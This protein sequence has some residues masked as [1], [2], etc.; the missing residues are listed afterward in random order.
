MEQILKYVEE[1]LIPKVE[2]PEFKAGD[3]VTVH[4]KIIEGEKVRIQQ[5]K[6]IVI[7][8][9][10]GPKNAK[11]TFTVRKISSGIG[12]ERVFPVSSPNIE[13]IEVNRYGKVRRARLFYLR[14]AQG[15][16]ARI[17]ERRVLTGADAKGKND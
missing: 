7:Q 1:Q 9:K 16:R 17:K 10:G 4:Y 8:I 15:K 12:V 2:T 5:F 11:R 3:N 6:G 14:D 13:K